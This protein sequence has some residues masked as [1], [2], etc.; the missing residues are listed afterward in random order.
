MSVRSPR[1][2][3][4]RTSGRETT[5]RNSD[6]DGVLRARFRARHTGCEGGGSPGRQVPDPA[7]TRRVAARRVGLNAGK[8]AWQLRPSLRALAFFPFACRF[9]RFSSLRLL[10]TAAGTVSVLE[11]VVRETAGR[12]FSS[13][14]PRACL[15]L[16]DT[17]S[18]AWFR[19][20]LRSTSLPRPPL[21]MPDDSLG[22][23]CTLS[24][25]T[26]WARG[27]DIVAAE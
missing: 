22:G 16:F 24:E 1:P 12:R 17:P 10:R 11:R 8:L 9:G 5:S 14:V 4:R 23:A 6:D 21:L 19:A 20:S 18:F 15:P 2:P 26:I 27:S 7:S 13:L 25:S 3:S